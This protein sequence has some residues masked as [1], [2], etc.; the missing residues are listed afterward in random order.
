MASAAGLHLSN[1]NCLTGDG[2]MNTSTS[3]DVFYVARSR[4]KVD[5]Q[6][7]PERVSDTDPDQRYECF[8][9]YCLFDTLQDPCEYRN[10]AKQNPQ[11]L[12][13][14][15]GMLEQFKNEM[16]MQAPKPITD[17]DADPR[18]FTGYWE[19]WLEPYVKA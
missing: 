1:I 14:T 2:C 13:Q 12:A 6:T 16:T 4:A 17:P 15:I 18:R 7:C 19:P 3:R 9:G 8:D 11:T 5:G 10:V